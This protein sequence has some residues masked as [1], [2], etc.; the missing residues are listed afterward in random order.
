M[1][2]VREYKA[3]DYEAVR[4]CFVELQDHERA[5]DEHMAEGA[6]VAKKYLDYMFARCA[7]TGGKVFVAE[8]EHRVIGFVSIWTKIKTKAIEERE[9]EYAYVSDLVVLNEHRGRGAGKA[10]LERAEEYARL[11]GARI[12]RIG[13]LAKNEVARSLYKKLGFEE[14]IVEL[15]KRL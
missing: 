13:V 11:E 3:E 10:L 4:D 1:I 15:S 6:M 5:I 12:L 14:R 2:S 9:Y 8:A 7:E